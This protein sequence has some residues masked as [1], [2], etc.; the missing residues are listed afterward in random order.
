MTP[1]LPTEYQGEDPKHVAEVFAAAKRICLSDATPEQMVRYARST[2]SES[3]VRS[4]IEAAIRSRP[5][6]RTPSEVIAR[7]DR[8]KQR[9]AAARRAE[10]DF[11][12]CLQE[13]GLHFTTENQQ[14][15]DA[16]ARGQVLRATP[17]VLFSGPTLIAGHQC[18][19]VEY[20][21]YFGFPTNPFVA[22]KERRQVQKYATHL[23]PGL[24]VFSPGFEKGH[25]RIDGV[26]T[27]RQEDIV[28]EMKG[29]GELCHDET[30]HDSQRW[31]VVC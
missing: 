10:R 21:N 3:I 7:L 8:E 13:A 29:R 31:C 23:G 14:Q 5:A 17:D 24:V 16:V 18:L 12:K 1:D 6:G 11:I 2:M 20:K 26:K 15:M 22:T 19:W 4:I 9:A 30:K 25:L 27:A 28:S